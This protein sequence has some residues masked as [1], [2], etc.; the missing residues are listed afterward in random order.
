MSNDWGLA[1]LLGGKEGQSRSLAKL[2]GGVVKWVILFFGIPPFLQ[3]LGQQALVAPL[4]QMLGK[5]LAF[6]PNIVAAAIIVFVGGM[7]AMIVREVVASFLAATGADAGAERLGFGRIFGRKKLSRVAGAI[8]YSFIIV[9]IIMSALDT[10]GFSHSRLVAGV[11]RYAILFLGI[12][13]TLDQS[14]VRTQIV[15]AAVGAIL[16]GGRRSH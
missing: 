15:T 2:A 13:L 9:P 3:A 6:L 12:G 5:T 8:A 7:I 16:R 1:G 10:Q 11:A 4:Q 14:G